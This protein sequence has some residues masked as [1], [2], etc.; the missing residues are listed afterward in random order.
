MSNYTNGFYPRS[1]F[2]WTSLLILTLLI[3]WYTLVIRFT[4]SGRTCTRS[5][6]IVE[7]EERVSLVIPAMICDGGWLSSCHWWTRGYWN[8]F[9]TVRS[10]EFGTLYVSSCQWLEKRRLPIIRTGRSS[11]SIW[12]ARRWGKLGCGNVIGSGASSERVISIHFDRHGI[13]VDSEAD[14]SFSSFAF[15]ADP[16][17]LPLCIVAGTAGPCTCRYVS[18]SSRIRSLLVIPSF[19]AFVFRAL[20][21]RTGENL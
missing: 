2:N 12:S 20:P 3:Y 4:S 7:F 8:H 9:A 21:L 13:S 5:I 1:C 16:R 10:P 18:R 17:C 19:A 14:P 6:R 11:K 15:E